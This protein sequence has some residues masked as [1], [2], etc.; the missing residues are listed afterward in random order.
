MRRKSFRNGYFLFLV[1]CL[2]N[3][4]EI[5]TIAPDSPTC[6]RTL[7]KSVPFK[8]ASLI[9]EYGAASGAV[10]RGI[11]KRKSPGSRF[12]IF[13]KNRVFFENLGGTV[14]GR[15]VIVL[16]EDVF[17]AVRVL[18]GRFAI[19]KRSVDCIIS[20]LPWSLMPFDDLMEG[21]VK[22][23]LKKDGVFIQY[24]HATAILRGSR[25]KPVLE[26]HFTRVESGFV[27][28]NLPPAFVYTCRGLVAAS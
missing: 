11:L 10:T 15:D 16:N 7:L 9:L 19:R 18:S 1:E 28:L 21:S 4:R 24:M 27:F 17:D 25:L 3:Y 14:R 6:V 23:L 8:S 2:R 5:G 20:T 13:E 26:T 12:I 22:P